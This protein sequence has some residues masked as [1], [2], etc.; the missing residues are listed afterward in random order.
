[1]PAHNW[2]RSLFANSK[3][4]RRPQRIKMSRTSLRLEKLEDRA[5]PAVGLTVGPN[6]NS[7]KTAGNEQET[8]IALNPTNPLNIFVEDTN[9]VVGRFTLNGGTTWTVSTGLPLSSL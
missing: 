8:T 1:M 3:T 4:D 2:I 5:L 6:L 7:S 9:S